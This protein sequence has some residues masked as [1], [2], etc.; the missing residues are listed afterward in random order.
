MAQVL[1]L[2][3]ARIDRRLRAEE[4]RFDDS[5]GVSVSADDAGMVVFD[6]TTGPNNAGFLIAV[7]PAEAVKVMHQLDAAILR[8]RRTVEG[9]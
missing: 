9:E 4:W 2:K 8:A 1:S 7:D 5:V 6:V 3:Q